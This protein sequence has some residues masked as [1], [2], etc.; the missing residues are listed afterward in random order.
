MSQANAE[1]VR[2]TLEE[3]YAFLRGELSSEALAESLDP[4]LEYHWHDQQTYPDAPQHLR[5]AS[6]LL[7]FTEEYRRAWVD[8]AMELGEF[9]DAPGDR[10]L[11]SISHS[12]R[13]RESGVPIAI[14]F[15]EV[16]TIR[17]G[18]VRRMEI[19]RHRAD[20]LEAAGLRE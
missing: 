2:R 13:G 14:H 4:Q 12:A 17:D 5:G 7:E 11:A 10:V 9:I 18:K 15:F 20:A 19:F 3:R 8:P 6:K 1:I 16:F